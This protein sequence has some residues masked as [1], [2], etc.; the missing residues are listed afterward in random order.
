[1]CDREGRGLSGFYLR[2]VF[3]VPTV[4]ASRA[5]TSP[6]FRHRIAAETKREC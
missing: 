6:V 3:L 5:R 1:V 2:A 4:L